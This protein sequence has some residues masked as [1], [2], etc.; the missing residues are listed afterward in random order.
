M[1]GSPEFEFWYVILCNLLNFSA[2]G[3]S[4]VKLGYIIVLVGKV[5]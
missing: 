5:V 1:S 4:F 3:F 2:S